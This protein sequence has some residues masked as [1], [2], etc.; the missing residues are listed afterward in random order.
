MDTQPMPPINDA[1][2][3]PAAPRRPW[4]RCGNSDY[5]DLTWLWVVLFITSSSTISASD[6]QP[7]RWLVLGAS[8]GLGL[9]FWWAARRKRL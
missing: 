2:P 1:N 4:W 8:M 3:P 5:S 6:P 7:V 9:L